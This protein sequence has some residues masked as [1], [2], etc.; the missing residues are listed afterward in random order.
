[1]PI[2]PPARALLTPVVLGTVAVSAAAA[3]VLLEPQTVV[4]IACP[5]LALTGWACPLCGGTRSTAALL[6]GDVAAAVDLNAFTTV[7]VL[8]LAGAW[9]A[10]L[11][12]TAR[13]RVLTAVPPG[14]AWWAVVVIGVGFAVVR[15]LPG[16]LSG[17]AP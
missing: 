10:W 11:V 15:N 12:A 16:P 7:G 14:W 8:V 17:L 4:P 2:P 13:G 1:M 3:L 6:E 5:F 9:L